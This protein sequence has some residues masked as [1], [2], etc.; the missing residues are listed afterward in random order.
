MPKEKIFPESN[1]SGM[2]DYILR[3]YGNTLRKSDFVHTGCSG[4]YKRLLHEDFIK[5]E[6]DEPDPKV[7]RTKK[8]YPKS[9]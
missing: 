4:F 6:N 3:V 7:T 2:L 8:P 5:E 9:E 1:G